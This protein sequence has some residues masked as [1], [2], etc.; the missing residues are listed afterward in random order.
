MIFFISRKFTQLSEIEESTGIGYVKE[1]A[2]KYA[3]GTKIA[4]VPTNRANGL[5]GKSLQGQL[6]LEVPV[7]NA[8][9]PGAVL[10]AAADA[11]VVIRDVNGKVY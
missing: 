4:N 2:K 10:D 11:G 6:Y 3:S 1:A 7:Q 9:V 8:S 5:A